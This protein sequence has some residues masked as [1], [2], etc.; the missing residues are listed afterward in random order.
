[1]KLQLAGEMPCA[2]VP[3]HGARV[4]FDDLDEQQKTY[5]LRVVPKFEWLTAADAL[6]AETV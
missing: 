5:Y 1:M 6:D 3:N 2:V 4:E